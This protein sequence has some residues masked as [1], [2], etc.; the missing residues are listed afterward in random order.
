M[1]AMPFV[2]Q[3]DP[4]VVY[5][6][7][8]QGPKIKRTTTGRYVGHDLTDVVLLDEKGKF[9]SIPIEKIIRINYYN[10]APF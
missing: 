2:E 6:I 8:I 1:V 7:T 10:E 3:M 9:R 5:V 4:E